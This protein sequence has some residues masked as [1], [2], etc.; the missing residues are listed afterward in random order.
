[1][2]HMT[3]N[4]RLSGYNSEGLLSFC[5]VYLFSDVVIK[6]IHAPIRD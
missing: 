6:N 1:M 2:H 5:S 4:L 3:N